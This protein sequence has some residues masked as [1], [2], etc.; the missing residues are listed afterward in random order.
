MAKKKTVIGRRVLAKANKVVGKIK[1]A[2]IAK[3][4]LVGRAQ[5][6]TLARGQRSQARRDS[7]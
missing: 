2:R 6:H 7:R 3:T 5:G 4:G 1:T